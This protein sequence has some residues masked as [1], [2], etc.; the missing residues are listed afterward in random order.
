MPGSLLPFEEP[1][2]VLLPAPVSAE[3][4]GL[5]LPADWPPCAA[6]A[7]SSDAACQALLIFSRAELIELMSLDSCADFNCVSALS[8]AVLLSEGI[9]SP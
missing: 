3:E 7:M 8:I 2:P 6:F 5:A 9:L 4:P 1:L